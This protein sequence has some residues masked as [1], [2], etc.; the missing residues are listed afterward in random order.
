VASVRAFTF[1]RH[2]EPTAQAQTLR[3]FVNLIVAQPLEAL[4]RHLRQGDFSRWVADVFGDAPLATRIR[5]VEDEYRAG[6][7][8]DAQDAIARAIRVRY[9]LDEPDRWATE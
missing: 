1:T 9:E 3:E 4:D 8:V 6:R 2:G 5:E 7:K